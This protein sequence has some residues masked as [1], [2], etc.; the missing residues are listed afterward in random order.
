MVDPTRTIGIERLDRRGRDRDVENTTPAEC[1]S[2]LWQLTPDSWAF[3]GPPSPVKKAPLP[4][5]LILATTTLAVV[6]PPVAAPE[7]EMRD[8]GT[9]PQDD[10]P[11]APVGGV[12]D[13]G[14]YRASY[15]VFVDCRSDYEERYAELARACREAGFPLL[16]D[17]ALDGSSLPNSGG[18]AIVPLA[19]GLSFVVGCLLVRRIY[20]GF[21][22][23]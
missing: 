14:L 19:V 2:M 9:P 16:N 22:H 15:D 5:S 13:G 6:A 17:P 1:S 23:L 10:P 18:P 12:T 20:G 21:K 11:Y 3:T 4:M 7:M 8:P